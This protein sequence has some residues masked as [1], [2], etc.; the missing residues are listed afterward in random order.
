MPRRSKSPAKNRQVEKGRSRSKSKAKKSKSRSRSKPKDKSKSPSRKATKGKQK[1]KSKGKVAKATAQQV[2]ERSS[3]HWPFTEDEMNWKLTSFRRGITLCG[4]Y[5]IV[6]AYGATLQSGSAL[7]L[8]ASTERT[9]FSVIGLILIWWTTF[10]GAYPMYYGAPP[11][12]KTDRK[13]NFIAGSPFGFGTY[14]TNNILFAL[15]AVSAAFLSP[16]HS[17]CRGMH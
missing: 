9:A 7:A 13:Y 11:P 10:W 3:V 1:P 17:V 2:A 15:T 8:T 16:R 4:A 5:H 6:M 12:K 14:L